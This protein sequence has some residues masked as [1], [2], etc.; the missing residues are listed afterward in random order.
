[1]KLLRSFTFNEGRPGCME[2]IEVSMNDVATWGRSKS[3]WL[4]IE[5]GRNDE[6]LAKC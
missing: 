3:W 5:Y 6:V 4:V 1:M 2:S